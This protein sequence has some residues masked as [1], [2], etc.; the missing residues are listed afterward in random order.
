MDFDILKGKFSVN[1]ARQ[2]NPITLA[3]IGDAAYEIFVR[4]YIVNKNREMSVH[5]LHI[6]AVS[7][8]KAHSQSGFM[9]K[10]EGLL[11]EE[12]IGIFK[13]GRNSKSS[14]VPKNADVQEYR[15]ATGFEALIGFL[16]LTE[17]NERLN[18]LLNIIVNLKEN[19]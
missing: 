8:V 6:E 9:K 2:L 16:Y 15:M 18:Y 13:R 11:N 7:F 5:K 4:T 3:F 10:I 12:E 14:T 1:E 17:Q 19:I